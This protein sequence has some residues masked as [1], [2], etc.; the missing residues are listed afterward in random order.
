MYKYGGTV[1]DK[2][3]IW[4]LM[5]LVMITTDETLFEGGCP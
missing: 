1:A 3:Q 4:P 5:R 2:I